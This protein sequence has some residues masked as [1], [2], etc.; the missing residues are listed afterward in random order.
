MVLCALGIFL[1]S[2]DVKHTTRS[3]GT[4]LMAYGI[5]GYAITFALDYFDVEE[6]MMVM[7]DGMPVWFQTWMAQFMDNLMAP[8]ETFDLVLL[9]IGVILIVISIV[10]RR[11]QTP[12][13]E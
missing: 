7:T 6:Q 3:I 9:I 13:E 12:A 8:L 4:T 1:I 2:R 11:R 5:I 10:Y